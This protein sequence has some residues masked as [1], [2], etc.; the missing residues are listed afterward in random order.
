VAIPLYPGWHA[1]LATAE[2]PV[3]RV[4]HAFIGVVVPP[5]TGDVRL[6]YAPRLFWPGALISGLMLLALALAMWPRARF[7]A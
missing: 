6:S 4:D 2:L 1:N 7:A 5:G 3:R